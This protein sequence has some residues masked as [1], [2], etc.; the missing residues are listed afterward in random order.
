MILRDY[1]THTRY[2]DGQNTP[3]EM[4]AAAAARGMAALGFSGHSHTAYDESY[5]MSPAATEQYA[6]EVLALREEYRGRLEIYLGVEDDLHGARPAFPRDYTIGSVH[7]LFAGGTHFSVDHTPE[8]LAR[9]IREVFGGDGYRAA[10]AYFE[11]V[12]TV[13]DVTGCDLVGHFDLIAKFNGGG[14]FF[15]ETDPRYLGPALE[16][17]EYL[18][19]RGAVFEV[20][21]GAM[22]RGYRTVPYPARPILEAVA[23]FGGAVTLSSDAHRADALCYGFAEAAALAAACGFRTGRVLTARGWQDLPWDGE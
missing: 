15:D 20:N 3:R 6:A 1:H 2:C 23:R 22:A 19:R 8:I 21:T 17:A 14:R 4:A 7:E 11:T 9:G 16:A 18:C 13:R 5:C 12:A 10:R